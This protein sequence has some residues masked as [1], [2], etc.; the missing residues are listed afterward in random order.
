MLYIPSPPRQTLNF[1]D[2]FVLWEVYSIFSMQC[3]AGRLSPDALWVAA[4]T[5]SH[6]TD[7]DTVVRPWGPPSF[8]SRRGT[9]LDMR[10][11]HAIHGIYEHGT[12]HG[13][14]GGSSK[15]RYPSSL[16]AFAER[17]RWPPRPT[18]PLFETRARRW[19]ASASRSDPAHRYNLRT[20]YPWIEPYRR[21]KTSTNGPS[22][23]KKKQ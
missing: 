17:C 3:A 2:G 10:C 6:A 20:D 21:R 7:P 5:R 22:H 12:W 14:H 11:H 13:R 8:I 23:Y 15:R 4:I 19:P 9:V 1:Q 18:S 16:E